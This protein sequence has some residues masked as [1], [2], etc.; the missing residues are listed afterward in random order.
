MTTTK[1]TLRSK[2][3][4]LALVIGGVVALFALFLAVVIAN[5]LHAGYQMKATE[6]PVVGGDFKPQITRTNG[7]PPRWILRV[8]NA[9][10][11]SFTYTIGNPIQRRMQ[12]LCDEGWPNSDAVV[13][14]LVSLDA[15]SDAFI[16]PQEAIGAADARVHVLRKL[17]PIPDPPVTP[18][19]AVQQPV[20]E[21]GPSQP[22]QA[23]APTPPVQPAP[24]P[25]PSLR[26]LIDVDEVNYWILHDRGD[27]YVLEIYTMDGPVGYRYRDRDKADADVRWL[28]EA[29]TGV[30][31]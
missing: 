29:V 24:P 13:T 19:P 30:D 9:E 7:M 20:Q 17:D 4:E 2:L 27:H 22:V 21:P 23:P 10:G 3:L 12:G 16:S 18:T 28:R 6:S 8:V 25:P 14:W 1:R 31:D 15:N 5:W 26:D 11:D